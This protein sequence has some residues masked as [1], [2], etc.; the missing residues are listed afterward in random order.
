M[1]NID[2]VFSADTEK[3]VSNLMVSLACSAIQG[4]T[5]TDR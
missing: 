1:G 3:E 4:C 5:L 2:F